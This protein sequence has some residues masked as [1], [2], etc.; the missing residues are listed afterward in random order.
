MGLASRLTKHLAAASCVLAAVG[1]VH[2]QPA[3]AAIVLWNV[4]QVIPN[5]FTGLYV[6]VDTQQAETSGMFGWDV[7]PYGS[8][9]LRFYS[10]SSYPTY[11]RTQSLGGASS[12]PLGFLIDSTSNFVNVTTNVMDGTTTNNGWQ[13][14]SLNYFGFRFKDN[15]VADAIRYG[16]GSIQVGADASQRTLVSIAYENT[17]ASISVPAPAPVPGP[18]PILGAG[19]AFAWTRRLRRR[20]ALRR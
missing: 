7:N 15:S 5:N 19:S 18:L 6:R 12:L 20:V 1:V 2:D 8:N 16:W 13:L 11:V 14:N 10:N 4:N 9:S 3:Q 17:G